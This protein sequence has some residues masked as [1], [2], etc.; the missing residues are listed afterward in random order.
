MTST[1]TPRHVHIEGGG[2][3]YTPRDCWQRS[4]AGLGSS[5]F[6]GARSHDLWAVKS[7]M[8]SC[9]ALCISL[10]ICYTGCVSLRDNDFASARG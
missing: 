7:L 2:W 8:L 4:K 6:W 5:Q 10:V 1:C 9:T 3:C